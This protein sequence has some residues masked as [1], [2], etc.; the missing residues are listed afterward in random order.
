MH[1]IPIGPTGAAIEKP[2][3][4]SKIAETIELI[5]LQIQNQRKNNRISKERNPYACSN[6]NYFTPSH[7]TF[8]MINDEPRTSRHIQM[9][10]LLSIKGKHL[11]NQYRRASIPE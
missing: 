10:D 3:I 9:I 8:R 11:Q 2:M 6:I 5:N 7:G 4:T 1:R